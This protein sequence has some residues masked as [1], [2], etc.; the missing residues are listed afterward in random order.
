VAPTEAGLRQLVRWLKDLKGPVRCVYEAGPCGYEL[1]RLLLGKGIDCSV[2]AP[3]LTPRKPGERIKTNRRD[4]RK[5]GELLRAGVLTSITVPDPRQESVRDLLRARDDVRRSVMSARHR[6]SKFL[7]RHG[8]RFRDGGNWTGKHWQWIRSQKMK[9]PYEQIVLDHYI[10]VLEARQEE[11]TTLDRHVVAVAKEPDYAPMVAQ[12]SV[13]RGIDVLS[14]MIIL[15]ELGDLRRF[16]SAS[17]MMA[18]VGLVPSEYSTG[19]KTRRFGI[20][21][22][23]NAHVRHVLVQAGWH[24]QSSLRTGSAVRKR[25]AD[26]PT[27]IVTIARKADER[28]QRKYRRMVGRGKR[29]TVAVTAVA[30]EL[31]GFVWALGQQR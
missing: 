21:K 17:Q 14:A 9:Q 3:S 13:L 2:A 8:R 30:R 15:S 23:G 24:Y 11:L 5:L 27:N 4:A 12:L 22:T 18:A 19:D 29:S 20:T 28:L 16:T 10:E 31:A 1:Y 25:R 26:Q 7:L 6:L